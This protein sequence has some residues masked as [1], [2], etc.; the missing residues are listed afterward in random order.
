MVTR[1]IA[2][3]LVAWFISSCSNNGSSLTSEADQPLHSDSSFY[4]VFQ[5]TNLERPVISEDSAAVLQS[6][7][8]DNIVKLY[9]EGKLNLAGP[10]MGGSG[11]LL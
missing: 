1:L 7:H 9:N 3:F 5:N 8:M 4:F 6:L 2:T 11:H 10:F